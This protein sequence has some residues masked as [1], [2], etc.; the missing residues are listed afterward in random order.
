[1]I[2]DIMAIPLTQGLYALVDG[3]NFERI[4]KYKWYA[5]KGNS[6]FYAVRN[7]GKWPYQNLIWMHRQILKLTKGNRN[8]VDHRNHCGLDNREYNLRPCT[9]SQNAQNRKQQNKTSTYKGV[10]WHRGIV[11]KDKQ[12]VGKWIVHIKYNQKTVHLGLFNDEIKAAKAYD[13]KAKEL[14]GEFAR[15]NFGG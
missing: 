14:F 7:I 4:N 12:Y 9:H 13:Q 6:T 11:C 2:L 5:R 15:T 8:Q 10:S 3:K 1:M